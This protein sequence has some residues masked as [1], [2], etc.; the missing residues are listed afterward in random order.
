MPKVLTVESEKEVRGGGHVNLILKIMG[1]R[2]RHHLDH[3]EFQIAILWQFIETGQFC[4]MS[5]VVAV[6]CNRSSQMVL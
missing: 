3:L 2:R 4:E 1:Q 5:A 6:V